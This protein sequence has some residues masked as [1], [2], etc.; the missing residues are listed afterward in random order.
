MEFIKAKQIIT[1]LSSD[2]WFGNNYN[3]NIYKGCSHGCI[4]CDSRSRCYKIEEFDRVRS[5][6]KVIEL[7]EKELMK[8]RI[9]G[10]I[11]TGAMSDPYNPQEKKYELTRKALELIDKYGFGVSII[12][13]SDLILRDL[14]ILKK[15]SSKS[16]VIV[17]LTITTS[18]DEL[19]KKIEK[20]VSVSSRRFEVINQLSK[21][22]IF[23]GIVMMPILPF[24]E[25]TEENIK[26]IIRL[27]YENGAKF[28]Y[29]S[30]GVTLR[31][32]QREWFFKELD[33]NFEGL[34][35]KYMIEY[36]NKYDCYSKQSKE[37]YKMFKHECEKLGILYKMKD[38]N[39][40]YK[41][42]KSSEQLSLFD[43]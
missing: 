9:K 16:P 6:E 5:K 30:F 43:M 42:K 4:Y 36:G 14:D 7:L 32:N 10:V 20:N 38:I 39:K 26:N 37:L 27:A 21:N 34:K 12:T 13:K 17:K 11:A 22:G 31:D 2:S 23:T 3:M 40:A 41:S 28:I 15:I 18:D 35:K 25:D 33:K 19:C 29:P 24:I 8:K 1:K